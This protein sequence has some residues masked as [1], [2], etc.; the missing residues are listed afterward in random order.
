MDDFE[1]RRLSDE[2]VRASDRAADASEHAADEARA[3]RAEIAA[4]RFDAELRERHREEQERER[5]FGTTSLCASFITRALAL[6]P[7]LRG[8]LRDNYKPILTESFKTFWRVIDQNKTNLNDSGLKAVEKCG[9]AGLPAATGIWT[10]A[11]GPLPSDLSA[12][13][14][15]CQ[16]EVEDFRE[17]VRVF[18]RRQKRNAVVSGAIL[19]LCLVAW[20]ILASVLSNSSP[21][22]TAPVSSIQREA[23]PSQQPP[24]KQ[25]AHPTSTKAHTTSEAAASGKDAAKMSVDELDRWLRR[26][27]KQ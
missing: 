11:F 24:E 20:A 1:K 4:M 15:K 22:K 9:L 16:K 12:E 14:T 8:I 6:N 2:Q 21:T 27:R 17:R 25:V 26:D 19:V 5:L 7:P 13:M 10:R 3:V 23:P 18:Q